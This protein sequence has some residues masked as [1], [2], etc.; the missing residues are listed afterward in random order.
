MG[1]MILTVACPLMM[2][3]GFAKAQTEA[4]NSKTPDDVIADLQG[5]AND[6]SNAIKRYQ[7][8]LDREI[9][10]HDHGY[11]ATGGRRIPGADADLVGGPADLVQAA[12]RKL[13]AAR[14]ISAR[15]PGYSPAAAADADRIQVLIEE[16]RARLKA[17]SDTMRRL[18]VVSAKE[19]NLRTEA[20][21]RLK[22]RELSKAR[23]AAEE[24]AKRAFVALPVALPD[25][26]SPEEQREKAWDIMIAKVSIQADRGKE[27][28]AT[29]KPPQD[30]D[31]FPIHF[32]PGKRI[33]LANEH[34]CRITLTDS[35]MEDSKGRRLFYQEEWVTRQGSLA[36]TSGT[37][38]W[39]VVMLMRW[40][41][42][43]N[44]ATGQHSLLRRYGTR[45]FRGYLEELTQLRRS[46]SVSN[47]ELP[48]S[49][50]PP[51]MR[52]MTS[53]IEA[54]E[55]SR[56]EVRSAT[57]GYALVTR[58]LLARNDAL[59]VAQEKPALDDQLPRD[60]REN[61]FAIRG[62]MGSASAMLD[63][64]DKVR[65]AVERGAGGV[66]VL[67]AMVAWVNGNALEQQDPEQDS[68]ALLEALNRSDTAIHST[69]MLEE[70]ALDALP[71]DV[72]TSEA[73]FPAL[74]KD[75][76]VRIRRQGHPVEADGV[77][78]FKQEVWAVVAAAGS[79]RRVE[80]TIVVVNID[81]K[82]GSQI[83]A[84]R[85]VKHYA[86]DPGDPL[87]EIYDYY[88]AR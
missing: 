40:A 15:R 64:E 14:M 36:R 55:R 60:V 54:V 69:R 18:F 41:V 37:G 25:A 6:L 61:L 79:A 53:A 49:V 10:L 63:A 72:S 52:D 74:Q 73:K 2:L 82:S 1:R 9:A 34:Y 8:D 16:A 47:V 85:E 32:E 44:T 83:P 43:V 4:P 75:L 76:I 70:K 7:K 81:A 62:H 23:N 17:G 42:A 35:G 46:D 67:E 13:F 84:T 59:L 58:E 39:G 50:V 68:R 77:V 30:S 33:T 21:Q 28:T 45:E 22:L 71:P 65:R 29:R 19:L 12:I 26:D 56:E 31:M 5:V 24:A 51:T 38:P 3:C 27:I 87:E 88:S 80:R 11:R 66:R 20:E 57:L 48:E 78:T 86:I